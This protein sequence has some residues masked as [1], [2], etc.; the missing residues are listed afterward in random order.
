MIL[1][2]FKDENVGKKLKRRCCGKT[3]EMET[4]CP[5]NDITERTLETV[6]LCPK[7]SDANCTCH[8]LMF[9]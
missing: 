2:D 9:F 8:N 5:S 7:H 3:E 1:Q 6:D 4:H